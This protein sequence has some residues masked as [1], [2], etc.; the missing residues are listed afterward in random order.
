[1]RVSGACACH[2]HMRV[3]HALPLE[4]E[5]DSPDDPDQV[6]VQVDVV[7]GVAQGGTV[8]HHLN[9]GVCVRTALLSLQSNLVQL[10]NA[11]GALMLLTGV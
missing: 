1:M 8:G 10:G 7:V 3:T 6:R 2:V 4:R 11:G 9:P 5:R